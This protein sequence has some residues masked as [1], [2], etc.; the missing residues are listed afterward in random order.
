MGFL[1]KKKG[2]RKGSGER[3]KKRGLALTHFVSYDVS[4]CVARPLQLLQLELAGGLY[5]KD[6]LMASHRMKITSYNSL[7]FCIRMNTL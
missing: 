2:K 1:L 5:H 7:D 4:H 3:K 6:E